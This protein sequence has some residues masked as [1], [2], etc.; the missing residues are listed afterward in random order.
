MEANK[1]P[2]EKDRFTTTLDIDLL[3]KIKILAVYEKCSTNVLI[4]EAIRDLLQ[5]YEARKATKE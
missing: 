3:Q 4:E 1:S 2:A 5:K